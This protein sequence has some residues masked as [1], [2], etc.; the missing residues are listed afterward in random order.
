M[1]VTAL[2]PF[3]PILSYEMYVNIFMAKWS[4]RDSTNVTFVVGKGRGLKCKTKMG[5]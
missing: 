5:I 1:Q 3:Q 2:K 4:P